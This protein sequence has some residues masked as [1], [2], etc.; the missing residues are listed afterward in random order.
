MK[1]QRNSRGIALLF[2][3]LGARE[4]GG[5][6]TLR[7]DRFTPGVTHYAL[8][9]GLGGPQKRSGRVRKISPPPGFD[10]RTVQ[11]VGSHYTD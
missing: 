9:K 7:P 1:V 8:G 3:N 5:R 6:S 11:H 10:P 4:V 2:F